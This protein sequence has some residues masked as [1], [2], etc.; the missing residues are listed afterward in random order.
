MSRNKNVAKSNESHILLVGNGIN[1]SNDNQKNSIQWNEMLDNVQ[2]K[3]ITK[4]QLDEDKKISAND[5][6]VSPTVLFE[7][8][9]QGDERTSEI[10]KYVQDYVSGKTVD[11]SSLEL[12]NLYHTILTTNFDDNLIK[13]AP[14]GKK[15]S[16]PIVYNKDRYLSRR[17]DLALSNKIF[18]I[19]GYYKNPETICLGYDHYIKNLTK[20]QSF[21]A[22]YYSETSKKAISYR[23]NSKRKVQSWVDFFFEPNTTIDILGLS[24]CQEEIDLWWLLKHRAKVFDCLQNNHIHYFDLQRYDNGD[25]TKNAIRNKEIRAKKIVLESMHVDV[26]TIGNAKTYNEA[27]YKSCIEKIKELDAQRNKKFTHEN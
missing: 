3:L 20:I 16:L 23:R 21:V 22:N 5:K 11:I 24:L 4:N 8:L 1:D 18:F 15:T 27:Y 2:E 17:M 13:C 7:S 26:E 6:S 19:H 10:K 12:W 14:K 9:C 25:E